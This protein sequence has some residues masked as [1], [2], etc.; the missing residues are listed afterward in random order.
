MNY[1]TTSTTIILTLAIVGISY[2]SDSLNISFFIQYFIDIFQHK[3]YQFIVFSYILSI[4]TIILFL[5]VYKILNH[6]VIDNENNENEMNIVL[7]FKKLAKSIDNLCLG[8]FYFMEYLIKKL[9]F[10]ILFV[11]F[12]SSFAVDFNSY[13]NFYMYFI[14]FIESLIFA[15]LIIVIMKVTATFYYYSIFQL[16]FKY[17]SLSIINR[18][19]NIHRK[20]HSD[21]N[22][23]LVFQAIIDKLSTN[24]S[25]NLKEYIKEYD[26][27]SI[28]RIIT[29]VISKYLFILFFIVTKPVANLFKAKY[30]YYIM[31]PLIYS[32]VII[33]AII[34]TIF[35]GILLITTSLLFY[36]QIIVW[37]VVLITSSLL[38]IFFNTIAINS[39]LDTYIY[40]SNS[41]FIF[42]I[43]NL[44]LYLSINSIL[45]SIT[46]NVLPEFRMYYKIGNIYNDI[47]FYLSNEYREKKLQFIISLIFT[48]LFLLKYFVLDSNFIID[49]SYYAD[50]S[51]IKQFYN[52]LQVEYNL[53]ARDII[54][55]IMNLI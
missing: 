8:L 42:F 10:V 43:S 11:Q 27:S 53:M 52:N 45:V 32:L 25:S 34:I 50:F 7:F 28:A 44:I 19:L 15:F 48:F 36:S 23:G 4:V 37:F 14:L 20:F 40:F 12:I 30:F 18:I 9:I 13:F 39:I 21:K 6:K 38:V 51:N 17:T 54:Y 24:K 16:N 29:I 22:F 5:L 46:Y 1:Y 49:M 3:H 41:F 35:K 33:I 47:T 31:S 2:F 26:F 55:F